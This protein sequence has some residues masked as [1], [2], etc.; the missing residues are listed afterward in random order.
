M[1]NTNGNAQ[2]QASGIGLGS[3]LVKSVASPAG[4]NIPS[5]FGTGI[6]AIAAMTTETMKSSSA[7]QGNMTQPFMNRAT[8]QGGQQPLRASSREKLPGISLHQK[9]QMF[10]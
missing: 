8:L 2:A 1:K 10:N 7:H 5:G 9:L 4:P 3:S 6:G